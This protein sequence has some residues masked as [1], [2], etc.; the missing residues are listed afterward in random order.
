MKAHECK[1]VPQLRS[2]SFCSF[3][4]WLGVEAGHIATPPTKNVAKGARFCDADALQAPN[5][6]TCA[7][8]GEPFTELRSHPWFGAAFGGELRYVDFTSYPG[9]IRSEL[10]DFRSWED[11]EAV[12]TFYTLLESLS[13]RD[14]PLESNDCAFSGP[15]EASRSSADEALECSGRLMVLLRD[16]GDNVVPGRIEQLQEH[17]HRELDP[18]DPD[19][20]QGVIG[21][22]VMPTRFLALP[23]T[24]REQLGSQ[25]MI[26]F[27]AW[28][29]TQEETMSSL[30]RLFKNLAVALG[31]MKVTE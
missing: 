9:L 18:L 21:T 1:I 20:E 10:E 11:H 27:W 15:D 25:L 2:R 8:A 19:F 13:R 5:M 17:L 26:S 23:P 24:D 12:E 28:G 31:R 22:T 6:K 16:L 14:S 4:H 7:Y 29:H 3:P 30:D